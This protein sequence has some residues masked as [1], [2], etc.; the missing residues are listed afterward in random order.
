[1]EEAINPQTREGRVKIGAESWKATAAQ[2]LPAGARCQV[3]KLD[4]VTV[5]VKE[6]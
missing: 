3:E 6:I 5:T 4:G 1:M 2:A